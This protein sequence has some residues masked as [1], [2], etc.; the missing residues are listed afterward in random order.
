MISRCPNCSA[1][2]ACEYCPRCGQRRI[3]PEDLSARHYF[4]ELADEIATFHERFK[5]LRAVPLLFLTIILNNLASF[6]AIRIT[7]A[8][9]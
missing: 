7:L 2:L 6:A 5:T 3:H 1:E 9:V 8:L 4:R